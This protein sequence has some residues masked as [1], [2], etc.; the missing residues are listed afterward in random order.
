MIAPAASVSRF[1]L[2]YGRQELT[3]FSLS[4]VSAYEQPSHAAYLD[5]L[6]DF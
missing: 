1:L 5:A 3:S 2:R 4:H 6:S